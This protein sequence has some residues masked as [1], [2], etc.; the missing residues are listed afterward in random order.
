[1]RSLLFPH[2]SGTPQIPVN[3]DYGLVFRPNS[4]IAVPARKLTYARL[5][6]SEQILLGMGL[7]KRIL[8]RPSKKFFGRTFSETAKLHSWLAGPTSKRAKIC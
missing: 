7:S 8:P 2:V 1:M 4:G 5:H 3:N 6:T